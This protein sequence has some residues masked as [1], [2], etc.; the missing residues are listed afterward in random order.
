MQSGHL[1][2]LHRR[3][4]LNVSLISWNQWSSC[5]TV[6]F[7]NCNGI[8]C[9]K[10]AVFGGSNFLV[11]IFYRKG[12]LKFGNLI[13]L[14]HCY[15]ARCRGFL[16]NSC[17][18]QWQENEW[19]TANGQFCSTEGKIV[20]Q[21]VVWQQKLSGIVYRSVNQKRHG[22]PIDPKSI[23]EKP[24]HDYL[25]DL[26][27]FVVLGLFDVFEDCNLVFTCILVKR[28]QCSLL[29]HICSVNICNIL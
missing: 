16:L 7:R 29:Y 24:K 9:S 10:W 19:Y 11:R 20:L 14:S 13:S 8:I 27:A 17:F 12:Q 28:L 21:L 26:E 15:C 2:I 5:L 22:C 23:S 1:S 25:T 18:S 6:V 3:G 4:Q